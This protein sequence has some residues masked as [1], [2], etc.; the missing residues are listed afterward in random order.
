MFDLSRLKKISIKTKLLIIISALFL[1]ILLG[2]SYYAYITQLNLAIKTT[3]NDAIITANTMLS[4]LN[5]M[6]INGT[7]SKKT[8]RKQL[9]SIYRKIHGIDGFKLVRGEPV[10]KEFGPGLKQEIPTTVFDKKI[11]MSNKTIINETYKHG[12]PY[13]KIGVPFI[14]RTKERGVNCLE[15]HTVKAGTTLGGVELL[16]SLKNTVNSS[17][18]FLSVVIVSALI[19]LILAI[20]LIYLA[21]RYTFIK[22]MKNFYNKMRDIR[23][24]GGDLS[25]TIPL[26]YYDMPTIIKKRHKDCM[27]SVDELD[28]NC[29]HK[30]IDRFGEKGENICEECKVHKYPIYDEITHVVNK[31]NKFIIDVRSTVRMVNEQAMAIVDVSTSI[32]THVAEISEKAEEQSELST[33]VAA[34]SE[35]MSQTIKEI[36]G[37]TQKVSN[38]AKEA[39]DNAKKG[40]NVVENAVSGIK[41]VAAMTG[42]LGSLI[43]GLE[44]SSLEIGEIISVINDI[45]DQTN[46]LALNAA[47]EAARAGEQGRGFAVVADEVRKLAE[48]TVKATKE[49]VSKVQ[50]IQ[51]NTQATKSSMDSTLK[52]VNTSVEFASQAG[53][54]LSNIE[55]NILSLADQ[56]DSIAAASEEQTAATS[57]ISENIEKVSNLALLNSGKAKNATE[58]SASVYF[59]LEK[60]I[61]IIK[62]F[63]Y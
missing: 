43:N 1:V 46:L 21:F 22:P 29:W 59:E 15:C 24:G 10:N 6:M 38:V 51:Q 35:E 48:R 47:I 7:I 18:E 3:K 58:E 55:K 12:K 13:L 62:K 28:E 44:K 2:G 19:F 50:T 41:N 25:K 9:F 37:N 36:A 53:E 30:Q 26:D 61:S 16:Y 17:K 56:I 20:F 45:A 63:K 23:M 4:S 54:S 11:L 52:E 31:F 42:K 40:F 32:E 27:L 33:H 5:A 8:D 57:E 14:A 49:I 39:S 60:L 34:A